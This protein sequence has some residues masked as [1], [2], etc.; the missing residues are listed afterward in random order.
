MHLQPNRA[1]TPDDP[2]TLTRAI[3][4]LLVATEPTLW[5]TDELAREMQPAAGAATGITNDHEVQTAIDILRGAGLVHT[6]GTYAFATRA[7]VR[8]AELAD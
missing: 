1:P 4:S 6:H 8:A 7:A 2:N 5:S 3:L